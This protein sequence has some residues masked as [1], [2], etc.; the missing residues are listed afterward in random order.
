[1]AERKNGW[2]WIFWVNYPFKWI[3]EV[4]FMYPMG[5]FSDVYLAG[6]IK[7]ETLYVHLPLPCHTSSN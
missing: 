1:M 7:L 5:N 2:E 6:M 4:F 3:A